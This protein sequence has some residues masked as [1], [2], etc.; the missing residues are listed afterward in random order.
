M[1][2][3][4][5]QNYYGI[6]AVLFLS[7]GVCLRTEAEEG[8]MFFGCFPGSEG[9]CVLIPEEGYEIVLTHCLGGMAPVAL[10]V[11]NSPATT[12]SEEVSKTW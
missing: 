8:G 5:E 9:C 6:K 4:C 2:Y 7:G 10:L 1:T 11:Q 3:C 12:T